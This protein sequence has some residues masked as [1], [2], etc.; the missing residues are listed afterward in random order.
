VSIADLSAAA[1]DVEPWLRTIEASAAGPVEVAET[2]VSWVF[3]TERHAYKIKKPVDVGEARYR[4]P[5]RRRAACLDEVWLNR[6]LAPDAYLGVVAVTLEPSG[7][8]RLGGKGEPVEWAIKMRR[9]RAE[10]GMLRLIEHGELTTA[11]INLLA[12]ALADFYRGSPPQTVVLDELCAR[13]RSRIEDRWSIAPS[14][15]AD[16]G[17]E[18]IPIRAAQSAFLDGA[19][20]M[21]NMRVCDGR[22]VDGHGD[23]RPE[24]V[25]FERRPVIIDCAEYSPARRKTDALDDLSALTMECQ[26][27]GRDDVAGAVTAAYRRAT[28]DACL[29]QL[30]AF[31]R[32]LHACTRAAAAA[33]PGGDAASA[34]RIAEFESYLA[35][36]HRDVQAF[37]CA[38]ALDNR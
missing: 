12:E 25:F 17:R 16:I 20:L 26:R 13:L 8:L 32:S 27:L 24:H 38:A 29:P 35:Q 30:E 33:A 23:L 14:W 37:A 21:L 1:P 7:E 10:R 5:A 34:P 18:L 2:D 6:R 3:V 22:V 15:P 4:A 31:Y 28:G 36:A 19:R 9:L 11:H